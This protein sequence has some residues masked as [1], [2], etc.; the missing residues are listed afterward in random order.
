MPP[1]SAVDFGALPHSGAAALDWTWEDYAP[2]FHCLRD[3][4]LNGAGP[5]AWLA[6]W[7]RISDLAEE[8][9]ARLQIAAAADTRD[10]A[11]RARLEAFQLQLLPQALAADQ[12]LKQKLLDYGDVPPGMELP[13][14]KMQADTEYFRP[15]N[16]PLMAR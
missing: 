9:A 13:R 16:L 5:D 8:Q 10:A 6:A 1:S 12:E 2:Y 15:A 7:S 11:K 14:R 3:E 4:R